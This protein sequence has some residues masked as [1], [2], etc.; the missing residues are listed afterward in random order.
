MKHRSITKGLSFSLLVIVFFALFS[1]PIAFCS[2]TTNRKTAHLVTKEGTP[3][4]K[5]ETI[6]MGTDIAILI[7]TDKKFKANWAIDKALLEIKRIEDLMTD[8]REDSQVMDINRAAG[9]RPVIVD[10]ELA[11]LLAEAQKISELTQGHFDVTYAALGELWDFQNPKIP[12]EKIIKKTLELVNYKNLSIDTQTNTV[13]LNTE[14]MRIG[15]GGIAKGYAVDRAVEV[16]HKEGFKNFAVNA[17][18]DLTVRGR[19]QGNLWWVAIRHPRDKEKNLAL[20]PISN[21]SVVTSGD[22]ER[23]FEIK[24]KRYAHILNPK[25]GYPVDYMQ[26]VTIMAKNAYWA[27]ALA[28]GVF[29]L[30]PEK[31][32]KLIES[33][34]KVE[35][36]IIDQNGKSYVS[37]GLQ[38][39]GQKKGER[40]L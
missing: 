19:K 22:N 9:K 27:D 34:P 39:D 28:T 20:I 37:K 12:K 4:V 16:I 8:W 35:G 10:H 40:T 36:L 32:L 25:T 18:G 23:Y 3:V 17:G 13:F 5:R 1:N 21:G 14:G 30:G 2:E 24:G 11:L 7:L 31:G 26:S 33:L 29:V 15:L 6:L 38:E